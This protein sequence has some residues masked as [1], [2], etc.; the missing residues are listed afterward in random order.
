MDGLTDFVW[1]KHPA[2]RF[3]DDGL[4]LI[5]S[6]ESIEDMFQLLMFNGYIDVYVE[7]KSQ[8]QKHVT[9][10][11]PSHENNGSLNDAIMVGETV[12]CNVD[13]HTYG[14]EV[15]LG[16]KNAL[17][18]VTQECQIVAEHN[19]NS[20]DADGRIGDVLSGDEY[21]DVPWLTDNE[22]EEWQFARNQYKDTLKLYAD[23]VGIEGALVDPS[24]A[25]VEEGVSDSIDSD[26]EVSFVTTSNDSD[27]EEARRRRSLHKVFDESTVIPQFEIG[28]I[29]LSRKQFKDAVLIQ[30]IYMR[31]ETVLKKNDKKRVRVICADKRCNWVLLLSLDGRTR[32]WM[33]KTYQDEHTCSYSL[34][35][36]RV[37]SR[38]I[39]RHF[40]KTRGIS[41]TAATQINIQQSIKEELHLE[42]T[43]SQ[44]RRAKQ[45]IIK[46]FE[47][48]CEKEYSRLYDYRLKLLKKNPNSTVAIDAMRPTPDS[49]PVFLRF[50]V[51]FDALREGFIAGCRPIIG[52]DGAFLKGPCKGQLL[53]TIGRDANNQM[54]PVAWAIVENEST[55][56]WTWF[57]EYLNSDLKIGDGQYFTFISD[58][59]K[60]LIN[61]IQTLFPKARHRRCAR[62][63]YANFRK[64]H[65]GKELQRWFWITAKST[66]EAEFRRNLEQ[67]NKLKPAAKERLMK[68]DPKFWCKAFFDTDAKCDAVDN[69][70]SETFNGFILDARH[71]GPLSLLED[72]RRKCSKRN[73]EKLEFADRKFK[74]QFGPKIWEK[75]EEHR[76][77]M[78]RCHIKSQARWHYEV[79]ERPYSFLVNVRECTCSCRVW[80]LNG[81]PCR[82]GMLVIQ[83]RG[84]EYEDYVHPCYKKQAYIDTYKNFIIPIDGMQFWA[85]SGMPEIEPPIPKKT[86][87]RPKKKRHLEE[88]EMAFGSNMSRKGRVMTCQACFKK[89]HNSRTCPVKKQKSTVEESLSNAQNQVPESVQQ[90]LAITTVEESS[91]HVQNQVLEP[92]QQPA[93]TNIQVSKSIQQ[94]ALPTAAVAVAI[95]VQETVQ[96]PILQV[97]IDVQVPKK[98]L[99]KE[100][101]ATCRS[102]VGRPSAI[103]NDLGMNNSLNITE[104]VAAGNSAQVQKENNVVA[105][106]QVQKKNKEKVLIYLCFIL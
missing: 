91:T 50:Y 31:R 74:G 48:N 90:P 47:G 67:I 96:Q 9:K 26:D 100:F 22:D 72:L 83:H 102:R 42:I 53:S 30:S 57:L 82:H 79:E 64:D 76:S 14:V 51:C 80:Q 28:M 21:I 11:G 59:Q 27:V 58:Q 92:V 3:D 23:A 32:S 63:I 41:A 65:K 93:A 2:K 49:K 10:G 7:H 19:R 1:Y 103:A 37:R 43:M 6:D 77:K 35:N 56:T 24:E 69:N 88:W 97:P 38:T 4:V 60:G 45:L 13:C 70:M 98:R 18:S 20:G 15:D 55:S 78:T 33:I 75:I 81:I 36:R 54:Y 44:A 101:R 99:P 84:E 95:R 87:G 106:N 89:G 29:F 86:P 39:A 104:N 34:N 46:E 94:H 17:G 85:D 52:L 68:L 25:Y 62:H 16:D 40:I 5:I 8:I 61:A 73:I 105:S 12:A 66:N 71:K